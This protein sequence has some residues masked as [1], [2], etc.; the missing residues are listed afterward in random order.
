MKRQTRRLALLCGIAIAIVAVPLRAPAAAQTSTTPSSPGKALV[1]EPFADELN[2]GANAGQPEI[3]PLSKIG[4]SVDVFRNTQVSVPLMETLGNYSFVYM[5][6]HSGVFKGTDAGIVTREAFVSG[7]HKDLLNECSPSDADD[8][9]LKPMIPAGDPTLYDAVSGYFVTH[10][11]ATFPNSAII[12]LNGC[13]VLQARLFWQDL[14]SKNVAT[15][16]SWDGEVDSAISEIA[17][18]KLLADLAAGDTVAQS[19]ADVTNQGFGTSPNPDTGGTSHLGYF[20]D[21]TNTLAR[22]LVGDPAPTP[23][24]TST[25][26]PSATPTPK[27]VVKCKSGHKLS[28]GKCVKVKKPKCK[29]GYALSHGK[30]VKARPHPRCKSGYKRSHGKCVKVKK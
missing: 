7:Q 22:A 9:S 26:S 6:T 2:L 25:S 27:P 29:K 10:H 11:D 5:Q 15:L 13:S 28:H 12:F 3:D 23:D 30:C 16:I 21:G 14:Q 17:G 8:C 18:A 24:P 20:G 4:F 1:L 19:V